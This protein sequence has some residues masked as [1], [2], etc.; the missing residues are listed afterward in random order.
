MAH[1]K[2]QPAFTLIELLVVISIIALIVSILLPSL[3]SARDTA[4]GIVCMQNQKNIALVLTMYSEENDF[5]TPPVFYE[6]MTWGE[7]LVEADLLPVPV[8]GGVSVL[9]C[10]G[11]TLTP[12][13]TLYQSIDRTY[14]L[15]MWGFE[16][17]WDLGGFRVKDTVLKAGQYK[18][19]GEGT[20]LPDLILS[21]DSAYDVPGAVGYLDQRYYIFLNSNVD[22]IHLRHG[23]GANIAFGDGHAANLSFDALIDLGWIKNINNLV[24]RY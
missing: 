13:T 14:A 23:G 15:P 7:R 11:G 6:G 22:K 18:D 10:P 2:I 1:R 24:S 5:M 19:A 12:E 3:K 4:K 21:V 8:V 17:S 16:G 9:V 20:L